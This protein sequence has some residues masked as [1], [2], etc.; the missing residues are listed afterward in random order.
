MSQN[1]HFNNKGIILPHG[2]DGAFSLNTLLPLITQVYVKTFEEMYGANIQKWT[3]VGKLEFSSFAPFQLADS[4][5]FISE[6]R[7]DQNQ[8]F[9]ERSKKKT[10]PIAVVAESN[11]YNILAFRGTLSLFE[12]YRDAQ[13]IQQNFG[14]PYKIHSGFW[15]LYMS[16]QKV[17]QNELD[18]LSKPLIITGHSLGGALSVLSAMSFHDFNPQVYLFGTPRVGDSHFANE[19][20]QLVPNT[21][22]VENSSDLIPLLPPEKLTFLEDVYTHVGQLLTINGMGHELGIHTKAFK[23]LLGHLPSSYVNG[24]NAIVSPAPEPSNQPSK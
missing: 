1:T 23:G 9:W 14:H 16:I 3:P 17:V 10:L 2:F 20:N 12:W 5:K 4:L 11:D 18:K 13:I 24:L 21:F 19:Y 8:F 7:V 15:K 6:I 22:R